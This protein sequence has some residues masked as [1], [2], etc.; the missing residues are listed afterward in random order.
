MATKKTSKQ[1]P[2]SKKATKQ[3]TKAE[4][5]NKVSAL[6][7]AAK[8]LEQTGKAMTCRELIEAMATRKLWISPGGATPWSTLSAAMAREIRVKGSDSRF[9]K[10]ERGKFARA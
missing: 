2:D 10:A 3:A 9:V 7:A 6:D 4:A 1:K 5:G 8:V